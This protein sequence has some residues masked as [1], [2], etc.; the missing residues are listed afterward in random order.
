MEKISGRIVVLIFVIAL[1]LGGCGNTAGIETDKTKV[2]TDNSTPEELYE[3][4]LKEDTLVV[5]TVSTRAVDT[6]EAFEKAYPG[7]FVEVRD[8]R[9]PNLIEEVEKGSSNGTP[10]CDVVIC[11]DNSGEFKSRLVD[12]G[13]VVAFLP[14]DIGN[15]M[16][17][18]A[19]DGMVSFLNEAE[20]LFYST[21][22]HTECPIENIWELTEEKY[23]DRVYMPNPLRS[24]STYAFCASSLDHSTEFEAAYEA[25]AGEKLKLEGA[26]N[27]AEYFWK[28][29]SENIIFTN[30]SDEVTEALNDGKADF[31]WCVSS[32]LRL[33]DVGYSLAPAYKL[34]PFSGCRTSYAVMMTKGCKNENSAKL[35]IRFLL[36]EKDG[37]GAGLKPFSTA[38]T[39]SVRGD[40]PDGNE[41][42]LSDISL[43]APDQQRLIDEKEKVVMFWT[44]ILKGNQ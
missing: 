32:K 41:V 15:H 24:F 16:E 37:Q 28:K 9:S 19:A 17:E 22:E 30:S 29:V 26:E 6:K 5:Y 39:W 44:D 27:A 31:G 33:A 8:L 43:I 23:K 18:G 21:K 36:G 35:F 38:G 3:R 14:E 40:V 1:A 4:A 12:T 25:Y 20:I 42:P 11:N 10:V 34:I 13:I 2:I 7:L